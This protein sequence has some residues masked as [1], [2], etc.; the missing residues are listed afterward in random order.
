MS[1]LTVTTLR[2][3]TIRSSNTATNSILLDSSGRSTASNQPAFYG[4]RSAGE[5]WENYGGTPA[6]YNYNVAVTNRGNC[7]DTGTGVFTCPVAGVYAA[8][9][10]ALTGANGGYV[11]LYVY[12][13]DVNRT[14]RGVHTNTVGNNNWFHASTVFMVRCNKNDRIQIRVATSAASIYANSYSHGS[15]WLYS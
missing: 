12:V 6:V 11:T 4:Y 3:D 10:G 8:C 5:V 14:A 13:N 1:S 7:Y 2:T 9:P 15:I